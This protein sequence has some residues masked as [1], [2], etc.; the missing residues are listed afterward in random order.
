MGN[1]RCRENWNK[2]RKG[3]CEI[4]HN[5]VLWIKKGVWLNQSSAPKIQKVKKKGKKG[6]CNV[7]QCYQRHTWFP[8]HALPK[9]METLETLRR[10]KWVLKLCSIMNCGSP[11]LVFDPLTFLSIL[12]YLWW[13]AKWEA[14]GLVSLSWKAGDKAISWLRYPRNA[15]LCSCLSSIFHVSPVLLAVANVFTMA[16]VQRIRSQSFALG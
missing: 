8:V 5:S 2:I 12:L 13:L 9:H 15:Q 14:E 4:K 10:E 7:E 16:A 11:R 1:G 3:P 6:T